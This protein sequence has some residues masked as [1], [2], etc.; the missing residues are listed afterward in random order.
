MHTVELTVDDALDAQVRSVWQR[1]HAAGLPSLAT[2]RHP[3]NRPHLTLAAADRLTPEVTGALA[4]LPV[5]A[6]LDGLIFFERAVVWRVMATDAL[7]D[8]QAEVWRALTGTERNPQHAP[9][10]WVPHVSLALR[11]RDHARYA[12]ELGDLPV[13][14]GRFVQARTY[15][16]QTRTVTEVN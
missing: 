4:G 6:V 7:R 9:G 3:T 2:H 14:R 13:A 5:E 8:L 12:A 15:D 10:S 1:L 11:A 16:S